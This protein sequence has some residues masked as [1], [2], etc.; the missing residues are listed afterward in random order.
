MARKG[1]YRV[2]AFG[3]GHG[4]PLW[5]VYLRNGAV[6]HVGAWFFTGGACTAIPVGPSSPRRAWFHGGGLIAQA[7]LAFALLFLPRNEWVLATMGFNI[8]VMVQNLLPWRLGALAS[9][10]WHLWD[11]LSG[12]ARGGSVLSQRAAFERMVRH[13]ESIGSPLGTVYGRV[14]LAWTDILG[15]HPERGDALFDEDPPAATVEPWVDA[16]YHFVS[17][18]WHRLQNRPL[19]A[20][21]TAREA[22]HSVSLTSV[23]DAEALLALAESRA[24]IDLEESDQA[25]MVLARVAGAPG[26]IAGQAAVVRLWA[27]LEAEADDLELATWQVLRR[28]RFSWL[29]PADASLALVAASHELQAHKRRHAATG[30]LDASKTLATETLASCP[31]ELQDGLRRRL[32]PVLAPGSPSAGKTLSI[33]QQSQSD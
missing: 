14:C 26:L 12:G 3:I 9:D 29:D 23:V 7:L 33:S 20:L 11:A 28:K 16:L 1:G 2:T 6:L 24:L 30:A 32:R 4:L 19:A 18:E 31:S 5:S 8:L 25:L 15:G 13:S 22:H 27:A 21:R 10:G 17:A